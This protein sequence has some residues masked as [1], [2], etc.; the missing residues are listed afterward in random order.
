[1]KIIELR[2][3][4]I[5][6]LKVV[7]IRPDKAAIVLNGPNEAGKSAVL[8]SI[9]MA[10]TGKKLDDPIKHGERRA[11]VTINLGEYIVTRTFT[12][13]GGRVDVCVQS[14]G[15]KIPK[16]SPQKL[17]DSM[18]GDLSFDPLEFA[19]MKP[20]DQAGYLLRAAS[21]DVDGYK[22]ARQEL[23]D[24]RTIV[25]RDLKHAEAAVLEFGDVPDN[26]PDNEISISDLTDKLQ[27]HNK[28]ISAYQQWQQ[29]F[30]LMTGQAESLDDEIKT[31]RARLAEKVQQQ[32]EFAERIA[33][34]MQKKPDEP[35]NTVIEEL[36]NQI[37]NAETI[38]HNVRQKQ[39]ATN[40]RDRAAKLKAESETFTKR[41]GELDRHRDQAVAKIELPIAGLTTDG[42]DV[43]INNI[44][45][46]QC[47]TSQ[48][49]KIGMALA[50]KLN[51][52]LR[53]ILI[54]EGSMLD[55]KSLSQIT[56]MAE[57]NDY[58]LWIEKVADDAVPG[59]RIEA[60]EIVSVK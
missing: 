50:M 31:L 30:Q 42:Q 49:L 39:A 36:R 29:T 55:S 58:Q 45:L 1:M 43:F 48:Q 51:P 2:S 38:N 18:L 46:A 17:L 40:A 6:N 23:F 4:N 10:L 28:Q 41:L 25:N 8:D 14:D 59:I 21:V 12:K 27:K 7:E 56:S 9:F 54:R 34:T 20:A 13:S 47:S 22:T 5:K 26:T 11:E 44:P 33:A 15:L 35:N 52:K 32:K 24:G 60:G 3:E 16:P 37:N 57:T 19:R 53:I